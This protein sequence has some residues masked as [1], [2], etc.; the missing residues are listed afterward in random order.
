M[1]ATISES[2]IGGMSEPDLVL[3][4]MPGPLVLSVVVAVLVGVPVSFGLAVGS[5]PAT[6][7]LGY[8]LFYAPPVD[9]DG[10]R[11]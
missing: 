11:T 7:I 2:Y 6:L 10:R 5:V 9:S 8:A 4:A 1:E 3:S